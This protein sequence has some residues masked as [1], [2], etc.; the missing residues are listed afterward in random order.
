MTSS[1]MPSWSDSACVSTSPSRRRIPASRSRRRI[2]PPGGPVSNSTLAWPLWISVASPCPMLRNDTTTSPASGG[3]ASWA[4]D[5]AASSA[6]TA[7]AAVAAVHP[8]RRRG[9]GGPS[10]R[11]AARA[12]RA[13]PTSAAASAA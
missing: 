13:M 3:R 1:A 5:A 7:T 10:R 2:G 12:S 9:R 6:V 8:T 4:G 11:A